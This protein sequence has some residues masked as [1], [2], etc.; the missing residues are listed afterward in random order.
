MKVT[1]QE[2]ILDIVDQNDEVIT[3]MPRS[4]VYAQKLFSQMRSVWLLMKNS[5]GELWIPR[6]ALDRKILPGYLDGS[7]VGH[8]QA[9]ETYEQALARET[10]EEVGLDINLVSYKLLG[11]LTPH[12]HQTFCFAS[13]YECVIDQAP[14]NWSREE[15]SEWSWV[16]SDQLVK[17]YQQGEKMKDTLL[18]ILQ[19]FYG[20]KD[21][22]KN[23]GIISTTPAE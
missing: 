2:E 21:E 19:N 3:S 8:V 15:Y 16:T 12:E 5:K 10:K 20:H 6:R 18:V 13:V 7:V 9:G 4:E 23:I 11:K 14:V 22:I 1:Q 17:N